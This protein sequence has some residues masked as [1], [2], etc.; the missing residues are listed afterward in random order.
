MFRV[1]SRRRQEDIADSLRTLAEKL[2]T[3]EDVTLSA[4]GESTTV[5]V[6]DE[7]RFEIEVERETPTSGGQT[8]TSIEVEVEWKEGNKSFTIE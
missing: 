1:S 6:P 2:E 3:G 5:T 4:D 7:P 8:E